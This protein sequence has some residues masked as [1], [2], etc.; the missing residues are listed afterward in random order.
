[1]FL[2]CVGPDEI[3]KIYSALAFLAGLAPLVSN[4]S[5][6]YLYDATLDTFPSAFLLLEAAVVTLLVYLN[7]YVFT[8]R[9]K[10]L[11]DRKGNSID[12]GSRDAKR[13]EEIDIA[14]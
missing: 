3:G 14:D 8:Q 1:M 4:P 13:R 10:M 6:R 9:R 5:F 12:H 11:V 2:K 7:F